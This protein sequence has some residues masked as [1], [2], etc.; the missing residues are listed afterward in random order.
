VSV[1]ESIILSLEKFLEVG[2][3]V[4]YKLEE[5]DRVPELTLAGLFTGVEEVLK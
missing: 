5:F 3:T 4:I 2:K 1:W